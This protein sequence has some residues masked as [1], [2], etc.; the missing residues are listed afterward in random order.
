MRYVLLTLALLCAS[1]TQTPR[2]EARSVQPVKTFQLDGVILAM[3]GGTQVVTIKLQE[4]KGY[5]EAMTMRFP[6]KDKSEFEKLKPSQHITAD[7][8]VQGDEFWIEKIV[9]QP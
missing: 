4:I 2:E 6:V 3:D 9:Q 5:M 1:C 7:V 8:K